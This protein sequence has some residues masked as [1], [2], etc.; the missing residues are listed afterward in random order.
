MPLC[1]M[2]LCYLIRGGIYHKRPTNCQQLANE[3]PYQ[4]QPIDGNLPALENPDWPS[5]GCGLLAAFHK[6]F[7]RQVAG[8]LL[9]AFGKSHLSFVDTCLN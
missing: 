3:M 4:K 5:A 2:L 9:A 6:A 8:S 1:H 7:H